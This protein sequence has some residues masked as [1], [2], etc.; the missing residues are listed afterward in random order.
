M[1]K[2]NEKKKPQPGICPDQGSNPGRLHEGRACYRM[3]HGGGRYYQLDENKYIL[4]Y[5]KYAILLHNV[6]F[7]YNHLTCVK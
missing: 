1:R 6:D 3:L 4:Y 5:S 2:K 7:I